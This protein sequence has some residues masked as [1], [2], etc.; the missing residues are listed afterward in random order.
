M[1]QQ[2][3][4]VPPCF[5]LERGFQTDGGD[6]LIVLR[7]VGNSLFDCFTGRFFPKLQYYCVQ[8]RGRLME[9]NRCH[10]IGSGVTL[11]ALKSN[12]QARLKIRF[13]IPGYIFINF[14]DTQEHIKGS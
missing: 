3:F 12:S 7:P 1:H 14:L 8:M 13:K 5:H 11:E 2:K 4:H 9:L 10:A 6:L